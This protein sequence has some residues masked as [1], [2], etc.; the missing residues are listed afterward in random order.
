MP[1]LPVRACRFRAVDHVL[2]VVTNNSVTERN[3]AIRGE[4]VW[5]NKHPLLARQRLR[6]IKWRLVLQAVIAREE[7]A[8]TPGERNPVPFI[9]PQLFDPA[10][11][12]V[13]TGNRA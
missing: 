4:L 9:V 7:I 2:A 1:C 11:D 6:N 10:L 8:A 3:G 5:I 13:P 12:P